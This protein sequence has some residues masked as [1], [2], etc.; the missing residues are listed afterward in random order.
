MPGYYP[1]TRLK[2]WGLAIAKRSTMHKAR[3]A[4]ARRLAIVWCIKRVF[5][6]SR[7]RRPIDWPY[8][9]AVSLDRDD[10]ALDSISSGFR[11]FVIEDGCRGVDLIP[12]DSAAAIAE[13]RIAGAT[14]VNS[15][16][17]G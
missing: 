6:P 15:G 5:V 16:S 12:G 10:S 8:R 17:I 7:R 11:T 13:I 4:L 3:V 1:T 9:G 2:D 14:I